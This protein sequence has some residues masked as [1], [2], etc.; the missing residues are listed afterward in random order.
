MGGTSVINNG[1]RQLFLT[2]SAA[3]VSFARGATG[4]FES[5]WLR[6]NREDGALLKQ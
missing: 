6:V 3:A 1:R 5:V 4:A 2:P